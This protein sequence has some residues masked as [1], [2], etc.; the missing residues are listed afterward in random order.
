MPTVAMR[1]LLPA[2][3]RV[4][5]IYKKS[6][7]EL[8]ARERRH[9]GL[10]RLIEGGGP[11]ATRLMRAHRDHAASL[12]E[13]RRV[14]A[15]LGVDA[16]FRDRGESRSAG[17]FDLVVTLGGDGTVLRASH[18]VGA[19]CP[20]V[21]INTAPRDSVG[22]FCAGTKDEI[23]STLA[24]ALAGRLRE[25]TLARM[26]VDVDGALVS[27]RVLNDA[28]FCH[29]SPAATTRYTIRVRA[30]EEAHRSSG[31][32]VATPA[33]STAAS[34]SA[35]GRIDRIG[36]RRLQFVVREPFV[37][38]EP[39]P[40]LLSGYVGSRERLEI[41]SRIRDGHVYLDGPHLVRAVEI[42]S[43]VRFSLSREQLTLLG[44]RARGVGAHARPDRAW[45]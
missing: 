38:P 33:G 8:Y 15:R 5:V 32:W 13:A 30:R 42:G 36:A 27:A 28:L 26:R 14:L 3:P 16:R 1:V 29:A 40:R 41:V 35:G 12:R 7:Y 31:V 25:T 37:G 22:Y 10:R 20:L 23:G 45:P 44:F 2:R 6:A 34:R 19:G 17:A 4:L 18:V 24:D 9:R 39:T 21:A 11:A 43:S